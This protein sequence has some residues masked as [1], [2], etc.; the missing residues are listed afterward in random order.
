MRRVVWV[1]VNV[2]Y[3]GATFDGA[4]RHVEVF[5]HRFIMRLTAQGGPKGGRPGMEESHGRVKVNHG[6]VR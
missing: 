1:R 3:R 6:S 2:N 4:K 5:S